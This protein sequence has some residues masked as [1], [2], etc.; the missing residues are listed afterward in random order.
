MPLNLQILRRRLCIGLVLALLST[1]AAALAETILQRGNRDEPE[2]LDPHKSD[3]YQEYWVQSDLFEGLTR[4]DAHGQVVPGVAESWDIA[5]DGLTWT[6]HLRPNLRWSDGSPLT[7]DDFVWS[8]RRVVD[9]ATAASYASA[10][11]P[12]VGAKGITDGTDKDLTK[13]GVAAPDARTVVIRLTEPTAYL[14][15]LLTLGIG[16]PL[17]RKAIEAYGDEW[18]RPGH[19]VGDGAFVM[20]SW[21]PQLEIRLKRNP[22]YYDA[23]AVKLDGV[24][25]SV[26]E[27]DETALKRYRPAISISPACRASWCRRCNGKCRPISIPA[28]SFGPASSRSIPSVRRSTISGCARRWRC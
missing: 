26:N 12:I 15:G 20:D 3:G 17:P 1:S 7:A 5:P 21:T 16:F 11:L 23:A 24:V 14:G 6:F 9:P 10:F 4:I 8:L 27:D 18:T 25:W 28:R 22:N 19:I 13:L 2:T